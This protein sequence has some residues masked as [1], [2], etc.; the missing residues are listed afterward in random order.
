MSKT[1][2]MVSGSRQRLYTFDSA[3][4]LVIN[5]APVK[6]VKSTKSL[7]LNI[8]EHLLWSVHV[9]AISKRIASGLGALERIRPF[10]PLSAMHTILFQIFFSFIAHSYIFKK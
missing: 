5:G 4:V 10:V 6:Q 9:D 1:E 3:A 2:F 8:N 7:G